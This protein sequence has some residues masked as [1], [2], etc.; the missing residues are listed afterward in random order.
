MRRVKFIFEGTHPIKIKK[1]EISVYVNKLIEN[2]GYIVDDIT[3]VFCNDDY[4]LEINR[5]YLNHDHFTD[6][7]TF[8]YNEGKK[9]SG[10]LMISLERIRENAELY[11]KSFENELYRVI[12]HGILHLIGYDD[13]DEEMKKIMREKENDYLRMTEKGD[14]RINT[15]I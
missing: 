13:K 3:I 7:I 6:I 12:F 4:L 1:K 11:T 5:K 9:I 15:R 10:D 2:E 14:A 8:N